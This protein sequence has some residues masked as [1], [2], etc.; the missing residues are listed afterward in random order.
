MKDNEKFNKKIVSAR[1]KN[2]AKAWHPDRN[3]GSHEMFIQISHYY[4]I[5]MAE[6]DDVLDTEQIESAIEMIE[7]STN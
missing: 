4:G 6:I 5:L 1:F 2:L 3:G 7:A